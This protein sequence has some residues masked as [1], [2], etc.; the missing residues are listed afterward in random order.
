MHIPPIARLRTPKF[1]PRALIYSDHPPPG[2]TPPASFGLERLHIQ[3]QRIQGAF[4]KIVNSWLRSTQ[5]KLPSSGISPQT[6]A[7]RL[8]QVGGLYAEAEVIPVRQF[9][10][11]DLVYILPSLL[12]GR[13]AQRANCLKK[14]C[15]EADLA[16]IEGVHATAAPD[17]TCTA[18]CQPALA[19]EYAPKSK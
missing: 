17:S 9:C 4:R 15:P 19:D 5:Q 3:A 7:G 16:W 18:P 14:I 10:A 8:A 6:L 2:M 1:R 12:R 13:R 11:N